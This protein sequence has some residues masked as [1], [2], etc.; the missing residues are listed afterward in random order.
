MP[1]RPAASSPAS[2]QAGCA[3]SAGTTLEAVAADARACTVC[4]AHLPLGPRPVFSVSTT[5]RLL[6]VGQAP[7]TGA[8][9]S[10]MPWNDRSG[11]RLRAWMGIDRTAFYDAA[12]IAI[13]PMGL[14]YPGRQ[15]GGGDTPP[16][17]ECAPLW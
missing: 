10:G 1:C 9:L 14:C 15:P 3:I 2:L 7:G 13:L 6:I 16:R 8:H 12:R 17:P 11:E 4:A 5:A